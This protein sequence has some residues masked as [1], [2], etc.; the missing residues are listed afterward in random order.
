MKIFLGKLLS[1]YIEVPQFV[2][3]SKLKFQIW[4]QV[5]L[6]D[7]C[8]TFMCIL[9]RLPKK[10]SFCRVSLTLSW[11]CYLSYRNQS[12][13]NQWTGFYTIGTSV[14]KELNMLPTLNPVTTS[15]H[16]NGQIHVENIA[17]NATSYLTCFWPCFGQGAL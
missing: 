10:S 6:T 9:K 14:M 17:A 8:D 16:R 7:H 12:R 4:W 1:M 13:A 2:S 11:R 15:V 5:N 3:V